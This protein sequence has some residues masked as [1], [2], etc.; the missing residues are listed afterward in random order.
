MWVKFNHIGANNS[1][2]LLAKRRSGF[3]G[4]EF[5]KER[6]T[7]SGDLEFYFYNNDGT[8]F[9]IGSGS[10]WPSSD[11]DKTWHNIV[12][13]YDGSYLN[14]YDNGISIAT[15]V[16]ATGTIDNQ[17]HKICVATLWTG[18]ECFNTSNDSIEGS[19]DDVRIYN[20]ARTP[21]QIAWDYNHG[22]PV[23]EWRFDECAGSTIHDESGNGN[24]GT[25]HLGTHRVIA[26]GTCSNS[27]SSFWYNGRSG[28]YNSSGSFDGYDDRIILEND[29]FNYLSEGTF[30]AWVKWDASNHWE[31]IFGV[32]SSTDWFEIS[33][34]NYNK[35]SVYTGSGCTEGVRSSVEVKNPTEWHYVVYS[36]SKNQGNSMYVDGEKTIPVYSSGD[37]SS[38]AFL[39]SCSTG[40]I[41]EYN[42]GAVMNSS[43]AGIEYFNG[44]IDEVKI[45]NYVLTA[46]QIKSEYNSGAVKFGL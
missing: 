32:G 22:K 17:T 15:P 30:G 20:Y 44:Q 38:H 13:S 9:S 12:V 1:Y 45:W 36:S 27:S 34:S 5:Y 23:A 2:R 33:M 46:E 39:S 31:E 29:A 26:T 19:I 40:G 14:L 8:N 6:N 18:S 7:G 21:A 11:T 35:F 42:I 3:G 10:E 43:G 28:K 24:H 16:I 25:L 37:S 4:W 41:T